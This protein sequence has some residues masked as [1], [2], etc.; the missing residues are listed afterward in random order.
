MWYPI[1][2]V[3]GVP[4][5]FSVGGTQVSVAVPVLLA[6]TVTVALWAVVPPV[7]VQLN[8]YTVVALRA[9][10]DVDPPIA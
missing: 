10:V 3:T 2:V 4:L 7:P 6:V 5:V 9:P 8:V 1:S